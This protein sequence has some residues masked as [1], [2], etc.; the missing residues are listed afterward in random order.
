MLFAGCNAMIDKTSVSLLERVRKLDDQESWSRF[1]RLYT[2]LLYVWVRRLRLAPDEAEEL[3]QDVF[4]TLVDKLPDFTYDPGRRFRGWL[5][6]VTINK[7]RERRRKPTSPNADSGEIE[8]LAI[9]DPVDELTETEYRR[10]VTDRALQ[11]METDF[12]PTSWRAF[13]E[14]VTN[15]RTAVDVAAELGISVGSVYAA[16]TRILARLRTELQGLLD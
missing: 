1:V 7:L 6:T 16:K 8:Q 2:P 5:W 9:T 12:E 10:Y 15:G 11:L 4:V 14:H 3:V 13:W